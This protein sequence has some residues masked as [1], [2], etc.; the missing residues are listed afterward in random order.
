MLGWIREM[1]LADERGRLARAVGLRGLR[2]ID[3]VLAMDRLTRIGGDPWRRVRDGVDARRR[4]E[5]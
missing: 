1:V 5:G 2:G 3:A 4:G